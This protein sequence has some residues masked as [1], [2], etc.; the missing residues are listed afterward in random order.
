MRRR[1]DF[2][3]ILNGIQLLYIYIRNPEEYIS[4]MPWDQF[5]CTQL[6]V[7][8][9]CSSLVFSYS[10]ILSW[11]KSW[12]HIKYKQQG[13][14]TEP[15][16]TISPHSSACHAHCSKQRAQTVHF[17]YY[18]GLADGGRSIRIRTE[19]KLSQT[20]YFS[21]SSLFPWNKTNNGPATSE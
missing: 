15:N 18:L 6:P 17:V 8:I 10:C 12:K 9:L 20:V 3:T 13:L 16:Q 21:V 7:L 14:H 4:S 2:W 11:R 1:G 19:K 5:S